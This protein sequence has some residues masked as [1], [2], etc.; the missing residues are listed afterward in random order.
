MLSKHQELTYKSALFLKGV[1]MGLGQ[2]W[3]KGRKSGPKFSKD[4]RDGCL[5]IL[6]RM[7][8]NSEHLSIPQIGWFDLYTCQAVY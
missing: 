1:K 4:A 2:V 8:K 5:F 6:T 3:G 7:F